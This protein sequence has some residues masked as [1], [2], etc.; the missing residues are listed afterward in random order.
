MAQKIYFGIFWVGCIGLGLALQKQ[1]I[2]V[3]QALGSLFF[4]TAG[5]IGHFRAE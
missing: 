4:A 2:P 3:S 5:F 1:V